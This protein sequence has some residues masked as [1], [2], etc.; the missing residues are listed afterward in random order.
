MIADYQIEVYLISCHF[1]KR[2]KRKKEKIEIMEQADGSSVFILRF[3]VKFCPSIYVPSFLGEK[4][5]NGM[6]FFSSFIY[7]VMTHFCWVIGNPLAKNRTLT[8]IARAIIST[9]YD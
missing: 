5:L 6:F 8:K 2:R 7:I 4:Y 9:A 1:E 3:G